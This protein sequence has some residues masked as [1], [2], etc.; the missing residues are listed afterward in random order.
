LCVEGNISFI[1]RQFN[2]HQKKE[3]KGIRTFF[4]KGDLYILY[5]DKKQLSFTHY[6]K[7]PYYAYEIDYTQ[8]DDDNNILPIH[9]ADNILNE[10]PI[11]MQQYCNVN[12]SGIFDSHHLSMSLLLQLKNITLE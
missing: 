4:R 9:I 12:A 10:E 3:R 8:I 2:K 1:N 7:D 11:E 5:T 6:M